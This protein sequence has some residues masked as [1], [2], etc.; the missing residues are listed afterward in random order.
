ME[1]PYLVVPHC[2]ADLIVVP[3]SKQSK[4]TLVSALIFCLLPPL[5]TFSSIQY[6][7]SISC[8]LLVL[9]VTLII[10]E[11]SLFFPQNF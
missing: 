9:A 10:V 3:K 11:P 4:V 8:S 1:L 6:L 5:S 2:L 7:D